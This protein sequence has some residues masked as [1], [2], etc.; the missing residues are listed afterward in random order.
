MSNRPLIT[1]VVPG[2][3][4]AS[5]HWHRSTNDN[6]CSRCRRGIADGEC[7]LSLWRGDDMLIYCEACLGVQGQ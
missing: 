7:P 6:T 2:G 3:I 5:D 4:K 1:D